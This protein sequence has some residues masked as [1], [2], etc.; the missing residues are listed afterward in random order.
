[1][2]FELLAFL[3][4]SAASSPPAERVMTCYMQMDDSG[5]RDPS[6]PGRAHLVGPKYLIAWKYRPLSAAGMSKAQI[7]VHDPHGFLKGN[8]FT[9]QQFGPEGIGFY[10]GEP[11]K[12][13]FAI[14]LMPDLTPAG[15]H[16]AQ[17]IHTNKKKLAGMAFGYCKPDEREAGEAFAFWKAQPETLP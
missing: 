1:M 13:V 2:I 11:G 12:D 7:E 5:Q 14:A 16:K 17:F 15:F 6:N 3:A 4:Q 9:Q 10:G 8:P